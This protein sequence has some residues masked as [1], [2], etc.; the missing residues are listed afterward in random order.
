MPSSSLFHLINIIFLPFL[1]CSVLPNEPILSHLLW[2]EL[3][4]PS[5]NS[6]VKALTPSISEDDCIWKEGLYRVH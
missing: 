6:H 4:L 2:V 3:F 1:F 5:Q